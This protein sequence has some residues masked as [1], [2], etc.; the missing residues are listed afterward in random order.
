MDIRLGIWFRS[1][2]LFAGDLSSDDEFAHIVLLLEIEES[3]DLGRT[4]GAEA[5]REDGVSETRDLRLA[6]LDDNEGEDGNVGAYDAPA[7][8]L[9]STL[10]RAAGTEARVAVGEQEPHTVRQ[11]DTLLH[12]ETL[13]VVSTCDAE[14]VALEFVAD[15]V[16]GHFLCDPLVVEDTAASNISNLV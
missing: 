15:R 4:L 7:D 8:G 1:F 14:D 5:F 16:A 13:F 12:R 3:A 2:L 10:A 11:K 9:A 6:L